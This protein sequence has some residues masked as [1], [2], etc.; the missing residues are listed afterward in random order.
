MKRS[1]LKLLFAVVTLGVLVSCDN[2][3][4]LY[5]NGHNGNG[6]AMPNEEEDGSDDEW[7]PFYD[8]PFFS[9]I[10]VLYDESGNDI[11]IMDPDAIYELEVLHEGVTYTYDVNYSRYGYPHY[12]RAAG[13][14]RPLALRNLYYD[15]P[16]RFH[17][18]DFEWNTTA[19]YT[20]KFRGNSWDVKQTT[21]P[22]QVRTAEVWLNGETIFQGEGVVDTFVI[23]EVK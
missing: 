15:F 1:L 16:N 18:C 12:S 17:F 14:P 5:N 8:V 3:D 10:F 11:L 23:L 22:I 13:P 7:P 9:P 20:I 4:D 2:S 19:E 6:S 21:G